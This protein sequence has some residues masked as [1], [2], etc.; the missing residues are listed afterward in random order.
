MRLFQKPGST[1]AEKSF[2]IGAIAET[3]QAMGDSI[4]VFAESLYPHFLA[5]T[6]DED[7]EVRS[8]AVFGL[9]ILALHGGPPMHKYPLG[10]KCSDKI[11]TV[12][13]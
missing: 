13:K 1:A 9:G 5:M 8:N 12:L 2:A 3:L 7:E 6:R 4:S 10:K 11:L